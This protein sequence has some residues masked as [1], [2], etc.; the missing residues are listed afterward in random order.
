[1]TGPV[2]QILGAGRVLTVTGTA[3]MCARRVCSY[4]KRNC[5]KTSRGNRSAD[6]IMH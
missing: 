1:M 6:T 2:G 3:A 4:A 5:A